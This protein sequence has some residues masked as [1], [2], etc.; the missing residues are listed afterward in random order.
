MMTPYMNPAIDPFEDAP[1]T[2]QTQAQRVIAKFGGAQVLGKALARV[3][4]GRDRSRVYR[5]GY[6]KSKGGTGGVIPS[7][8]I[9]DVLTAA[10]LEGVHLTAE[11][12]D[13][14][15]K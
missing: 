5:W 6:P 8:V 12:L 13:P 2:R 9:A 4:S 11:D 1:D 3:N 15:P 14:R 10:R 7:S